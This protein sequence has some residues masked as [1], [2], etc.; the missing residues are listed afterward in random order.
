MLT[1]VLDLKED[2]GRAH[3]QISATVADPDPDTSEVEKRYFTSQPVA[4]AA[5]FH[6][7][8]KPDPPKTD[9]GKCRN[10]PVGYFLLHIP[11][12]CTLIRAMHQKILTGWQFTSRNYQSISPPISIGDNSAKSAIYPYGNYH[13]FGLAET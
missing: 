5:N 6:R 8:I 3:A 13:G 12:Q 7:D 4:M 11:Y 10:S 2:P 9:R 1:A